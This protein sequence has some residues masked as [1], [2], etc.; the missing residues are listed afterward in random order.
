MAMPDSKLIEDVSLTDPAFWR[1]PDREAVFAAFRNVAPVSWQVA[2]K[3]VARGGF[4]SLTRFAEVE[5]VS[6]DWKTFSSRFGASIEDETEQTAQIIG[7]MLNMDAPE[8]VRLRRIVNKS[9]A[10][11]SM[12]SLMK[13]IDTNAAQ[14]I[15]AVIDKGE[16]DFARDIAI[17]YPVAVI[18]DLLGVPPADRDFLQERTTTALCSDLPEFGGREGSGFQAFVDLNDYGAQMARE[19]RTRPRDDLIGLIVASKASGNPLSEEEVGI[20][21][22]LL[23]TAGIETT[24]TGTSQGMLALLN[25]PEQHRRWIENFDAIGDYAVEELVRYTTPIIHFAR[26]A[27]KNVVLGG[28]P[29][30]AG[31]KVV[32]WYNS[33]N[34]DEDEFTDPDNLDLGRTHNPHHGFGGGGRHFCLGANLARAE[35]KAIFKEVL[36]R[37]PDLE[38][39]VPPVLMPSRFVNG[40]RSMPCQFSPG[41]KIS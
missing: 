9:F 30:S 41:Q 17:P 33:A 16:C 36:T 35:M 14:L 40:V 11:G 18:C 15:D 23:V 1:R 5:R 4:W 7:G 25:H 10:P 32:M 29:V 39:T 3:N 27:T 24:G 22:Q 38:I 21:F 28:Q 12:T 20:Y 2:T 8:H 26:T 34:R 13:S 6:R 37:L 19:R 31:D